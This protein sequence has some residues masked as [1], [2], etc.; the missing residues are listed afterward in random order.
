MA[1][2]KA[3]PPLIRKARF[4]DRC[5]LC[6]LPVNAGDS[7]AWTADNVLSHMQCATD[8]DAARLARKQRDAAQALKRRAR[9]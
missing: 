5:R 4:D 1:N 6:L 8:F 9:R 2:H 7:A 3:R